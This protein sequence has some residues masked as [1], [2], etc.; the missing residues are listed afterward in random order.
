MLPRNH[1]QE[2]LSRAYVRAIAAQAG[3]LCS[4]PE[5]DFGTGVSAVRVANC[6]RQSG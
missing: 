4:Q 1:R 6:F 2:A 5:P 3:L